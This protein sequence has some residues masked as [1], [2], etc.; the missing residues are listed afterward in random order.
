MILVVIQ[1]MILVVIQCITH[2]VHSRWLIHAARRHITLAVTPC[3]QG[4]ANQFKFLDGKNDPP[5]FM[6]DHFYFSQLTDLK[7]PI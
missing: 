2:A 1:C 6:V 5:P 7:K 4:A 3:I